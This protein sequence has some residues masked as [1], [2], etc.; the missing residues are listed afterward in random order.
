VCVPTDD[1]DRTHTTTTTTKTIL[2]YLNPGGIFRPSPRDIRGNIIFLRGS[3]TLCPRVFLTL[4]ISHFWEMTH[5]QFFWCSFPF[6]CICICVISIKHMP[7]W[8]GV[9]YV[10]MCLQ[11]AVTRHHG[12][13][14]CPGR[15]FK[16]ALMLLFHF[17]SCRYENNNKPSQ[18]NRFFYFYCIFEFIAAISQF[19]QI[20][21]QTLYWGHFLITWQW[22]LL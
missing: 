2:N 3:F 11:T 10:F 6:W 9:S 16:H 13:R 19:F 20:N 5:N 8:W 15:T 21:L 7:Y 14:C 17:V 18:S 1:T 12:N 22:V 4:V